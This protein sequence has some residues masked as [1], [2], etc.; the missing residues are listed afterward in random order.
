MGRGNEPTLAEQIA[1]DPKPQRGAKGLTPDQLYP[2]GATM[3]NLCCSGTA[4]GGYSLGGIV[5]VPGSSS[6]GKSMLALTSMAEGV[7]DPRFKG[8][9]FIRDDA[10]VSD[11]FDTGY[12]F[13][14]EFVKRVESPPLG[15][16]NTIEDFEHNI[17]TVIKKD[18]HPVIYHLDSLDS[19]SS[20]AEL[21]KELKK[22][23]AAAKSQAAVDAIKGSYGMEKAK[24]LGTILR[25]VNQEL[26]KTN[27]LLMI[28][29]QL[30]AKIGATQWESPWCTSGGEA[31]FFYSTHQVWLMGAGAIKSEKVE[32]GNSVNVKVKKNKLTGK[33]RECRFNIFTDYGV[34]DIGSMVDWLLEVG[35]WKKGEGGNINAGTLMEGLK[36]TRPADAGSTGTLIPQIEEHGLIEN[37][38]ELVEYY[39]GEREER[40]RTGRAPRF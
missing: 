8:Y 23:L 10:E 7:Y 37:L 22:S 39:W 33:K 3:L 38:R 6:A 14:P 11:Q 19:L 25:M 36:G 12:L 34:D 40:L 16:S 21:D 17:M 35:E 9:K 27:S 24:I 26:E 20:T 18:K 4:K 31:P 15:Y 2:T 5:T 29:Q 32:I 1:A 13:G 30:R 28:V